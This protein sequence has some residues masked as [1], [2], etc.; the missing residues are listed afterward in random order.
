MSEQ[1]AQPRP[2][3][4]VTFEEAQAE[5]ESTLHNMTDEERLELVS[6]VERRMEWIHRWAGQGY[7]ISV[8]YTQTE[9]AVMIAGRKEPDGTIR[10]EEWKE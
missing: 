2:R 3:R 1:S 7:T 4:L 6:A 8:D 10:I 9:P 5:L